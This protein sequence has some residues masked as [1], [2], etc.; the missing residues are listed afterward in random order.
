MY[1]VSAPAKTCD[2][3]SDFRPDNANRPGPDNG[4]DPAAAIFPQEEPPN[5]I[6]AMEGSELAAKILQLHAAAEESATAE[7]RSPKLVVD[8]DDADLDIPGVL[9]RPRVNFSPPLEA[10]RPALDRVRQAA[11]GT[12]RQGPSLRTLVAGTVLVTVCGVAAIAVGMPG[13]L[14]N[15][16]DASLQVET[17]RIVAEPTIGSLIDANI[18]IQ[19]EQ[20]SGALKPALPFVAE[21]DPA[22]IAN[23]KERIREA[24]AQREFSS[25]ARLTTAFPRQDAAGHVR[26]AQFRL[27]TP[28]T[29]SPLR[30][31]EQ[32]SAIAIAATSPEAHSVSSPVL[33]GPSSSGAE[34][35]VGDLRLPSEAA[36]SEGTTSPSIQ[37]A[38]A[39][40]LPSEEAFPNRARTLAS[41]NLR[42]DA[43]KDAPVTAVI[44]AGTEIRFNECGVWWCGVSYKGQT[45]YV[46]QKYLDRAEAAQ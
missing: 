22:Q 36:S 18:A 38:E 10:P 24:F 44:A 23:A 26:K 12:F 5:E 14:L 8:P 43:E 3:Q 27:E 1:A 13:L 4:S 45:G 41:V 46:G 28:T 40:A 42:Q 2:L 9:R 16:D 17:Q 29:R 32:P 31:Q 11:A 7:S 19:G 34:R 39:S 35:A 15:G 33:P 37:T 6:R 30:P 20:L 21:A 25:S